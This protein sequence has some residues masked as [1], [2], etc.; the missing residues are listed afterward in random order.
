VYDKL[1]KKQ[2]ELFPEGVANALAELIAEGAVAPGRE[3]D[4]AIYVVSLLAV[5]LG[6]YARFAR[7]HPS[8]INVT[9]SQTHR[10]ASEGMP[11][12]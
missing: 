2:R 10:G 11:S 5:P 8:Y 12:V 9:V 6:S 4:V 1:S 3:R 7:R